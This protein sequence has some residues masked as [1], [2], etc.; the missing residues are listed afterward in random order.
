[1]RPAF[2]LRRGPSG[3]VGK[4][5]DTGNSNARFGTGSF[6]QII[7]A[8]NGGPAAR[9]TDIPRRIIFWLAT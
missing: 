1:V 5:A 6:R 2:R 3:H 4:R 7:E 9:N 8:F